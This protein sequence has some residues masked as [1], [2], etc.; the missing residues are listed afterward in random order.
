M[1]SKRI[2]KTPKL[3]NK[4]KQ[5]GLAVGEEEKVR[6]VARG[7]EQLPES[8]GAAKEGKASNVG[9]RQ[10]TS[11]GSQGEEEDTRVVGEREEFVRV[12]EKSSSV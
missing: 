5:L 8:R 10:E 2:L 1:E 6:E 9:W 3:N 4:N 11:C 12:R 7:A